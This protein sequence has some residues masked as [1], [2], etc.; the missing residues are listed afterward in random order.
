MHITTEATCNTFTLHG[1]VLWN[2]SYRFN[3]L[4]TPGTSLIIEVFFHMTKYDSSYI[5]WHHG[6]GEQRKTGLGNT[7]LQHSIKE[8]SPIQYFYGI[9]GNKKSREI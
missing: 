9:R 7:H 5:H 2:A 4:H 1:L 3:R 8:S 6:E